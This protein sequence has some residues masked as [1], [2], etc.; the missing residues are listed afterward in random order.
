MIYSIQEAAKS[1]ATSIKIV[2]RLVASGELKASK[3]RGK[4]FIQASD[5]NSFRNKNILYTKSNENILPFVGLESRRLNN[6][7]T[8]RPLNWIDISDCWEKP[9]SQDLTFVDLFC[10]AG[11]LSKGLEMAGIQG[12]CG[13]D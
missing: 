3:Q 4:F 5:L 11:G 7:K 1:M 8:E 6:A 2:R 13:L 9:K 10:G 12:I